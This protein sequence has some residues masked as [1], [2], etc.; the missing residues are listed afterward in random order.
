MNY[1]ESYGTLIALPPAA[2]AA[3]GRPPG[4]IVD[5]LER[6]PGRSVRHGHGAPVHT[7]AQNFLSFL[8]VPAQEAAIELLETQV[9]PWVRQ[10]QQAGYKPETVRSYRYCL[11]LLIKNALQ[12]GWT[13]PQSVMPTAWIAVFNLATEKQLKS[14]IRFAVSI[15]KTPS[16]FTED[17][18]AAWVQQG[19]QRGRTLGACKGNASHFRGLLAKP[20]LSY[21]QPML[22]T[23]PTG[24][25]T[26]LPN[27]QPQL[28]AEVQALLA[29][30][31]QEFHLE[32]N[33]SPI[34]P[35][36]A[37][38]LLASFVKLTGFVQNVRGEAP[39]ESLVDLVT[40]N[41]VGKYVSW[42]LNERKVHG[43]TLVAEL[44]R[45]RAS[46]NDN[47]SYSEWNLEWF[48]NILKKLPRENRA[49]IDRRKEKRYIPYRVANAIPD[50]I[51]EAR[52]RSK[53]MSDSELAASHRDELLM[54]WLVILPW[55]QRNLRE[56]RISGGRHQN[57]SLKPIRQLCAA[58]KPNWLAVRVA[59]DSAL[60]VWQ[61]YFTADETKCKNAF[62]AFL[63]AE[64]ALKL[65]EYLE[66][67][68]KLIP[69]GQP[70]P[71][72]LFL[73]DR[74]KALSSAALRELVGELTCR[75]A[76]V[77]VNP[78]LFRDIV[79]YE[80]L[81]KHPEDFLTLSKV[82]WHRTIEFTLKIYGSRFDESTGIARMDDWRAGA[83]KAA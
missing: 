64:L 17:D 41:N 57:I 37:T 31:T 47:P 39:V 62:E 48:S 25:G 68:H 71:G 38:G 69:V 13:R 80:W 83:L 22:R 27:M 75:Y 72:T 54:L 55:R 58:S 7:A 10:L 5:L 32:R 42:A 61:I 77:R 8:A 78:H 21:L 44:S 76:S 66:H 33:G 73:N 60:P 23:Q 52:R 20:E 40:R 24:Y 4:M 1:D 79:A 82:L 65:E 51:R 63:P 81:A 9:E 56:C 53:G 12:L 43:Q 74:G 19:V 26:P 49:A 14:I 18:L 46:F 6:I 67:R 28:R 2:E 45:M 36:T 50:M 30:R 59:A 70:D 35:A 29:F 15:G 3:A 16:T 11:N 34:R